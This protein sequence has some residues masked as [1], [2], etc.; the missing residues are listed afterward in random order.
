MAFSLRLA[1]LEIT[2]SHSQNMYQHSQD[3]LRQPFIK[4]QGWIWPLTHQQSIRRGLPLRSLTSSTAINTSTLI[5]HPL[6]MAYIIKPTES[7]DSRL[8]SS[9]FLLGIKR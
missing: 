2:K 9:Q 6:S 7:W 3:N 4:W 8:T 1:V 5:P